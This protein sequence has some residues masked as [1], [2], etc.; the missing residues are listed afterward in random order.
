MYCGNNKT[1]LTSQKQIAGAF[2]NLIKDNKY[3]AISITM[4][5]RKAD[6]SRQTFYSIFQSKE[7]IIS[8]LLEE[9]HLFTPANRCENRPMSLREMSREYSVYIMKSR[10]ILTLMARNKVFYML[11]DCLYDSFIACN[12]LRTEISKEQRA[13]MAE[14]FAG[15]LSGIARTYVQLG[16]E[17]SADALDEMIYQLFSGNMLK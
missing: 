15:G 9:N 7:N 13:F 16:G 2:L 5:C 12:C 10:E 4:I 6:V 17:M 3:E 14:F 8:Y 11:H 1:A